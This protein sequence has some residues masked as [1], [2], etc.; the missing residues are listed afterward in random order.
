MVRLDRD[1]YLLRIPP[2]SHLQTGLRVL[3]FHWILLIVIRLN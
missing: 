2:G 1:V 3:D